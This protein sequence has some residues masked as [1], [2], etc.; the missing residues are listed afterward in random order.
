[1]GD[2]A[3]FRRLPSFRQSVV[4]DYPGDPNAVVLENAS[5]ALGLDR[6]MRGAV[7]PRADRFF[8]IEKGE[9]QKL[10]RLGQTL[11]PLNRDESV[12]RLEIGPQRRRQ[13]KVGLGA[14]LRRPNLKDHR[15][16]GRTSGAC[17]AEARRRKMRSSRC[18][19]CS[20]LANS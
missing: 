15:D 5:T 6:A 12:D 3:V 18:M 4:A 20:R 1:M 9:R 7:P 17:G 8:V 14:P 16:H 10:A 2:A 13:L 11:K 19:N